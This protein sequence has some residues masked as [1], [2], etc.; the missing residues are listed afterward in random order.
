M[1]PEGFNLASNLAK[2]FLVTH[3]GLCGY[4]CLSRALGM[5]DGWAGGVNFVLQLLDHKDFLNPNLFR[6]SRKYFYHR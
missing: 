1:D 4:R 3:D 5:T 2:L 6:M